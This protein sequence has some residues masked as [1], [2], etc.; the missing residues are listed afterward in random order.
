MAVWAHL[1]EVSERVRVG[2]GKGCVEQRSTALPDPS[3]L[4]ATSPYLWCTLK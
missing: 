4:L 3:S 1:R 2:S